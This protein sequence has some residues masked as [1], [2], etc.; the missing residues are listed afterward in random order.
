[1]LSCSR[2]IETHKKLCSQCSVYEFMCLASSLVLSVKQLC[3]G[4]IS[5]ELY[6]SL[7]CENEEYSLLGRDI[8]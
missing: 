6:V 4:I 3:T 7:G 5:C 8:M 2:H 1:V